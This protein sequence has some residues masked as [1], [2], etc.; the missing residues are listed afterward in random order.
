MVSILGLHSSTF[1]YGDHHGDREGRGRRVVSS[2]VESLP[3][4]QR[5]TSSNLVLR[6]NLYQEVFYGCKISQTNKNQSMY[7]LQE[8]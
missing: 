1:S 3:S 4:K 5:V 6:S 7:D 2:A 8:T